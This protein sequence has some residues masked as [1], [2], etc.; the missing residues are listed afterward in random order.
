MNG[1]H[2]TKTLKEL[3]PGDIIRVQVLFAENTRDYYN[4]YTP[5]EIRG[6][7][8]TDRFGQSGKNRMVIFLGRDG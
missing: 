4:G 5:E 2:R 1:H 3:Q 6:G 8:Y 7:K